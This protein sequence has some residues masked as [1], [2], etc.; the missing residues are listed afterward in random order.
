MGNI[1]IVVKSEPGVIINKEKFEQPI[2]FEGIHN[3]PEDKR[4]GT[5]IDHLFERKPI[6]ILVEVKEK[7]KE[8][9]KG[10]RIM[11]ENLADNLCYYDVYCFLVW[12]E[13]KEGPIYLKD[14]IVSKL[15]RKNN[16]EGLKYAKDKDGNEIINKYSIIKGKWRNI[17][18]EKGKKMTYKEVFNK[19]I[20]E[21]LNGKE[22]KRT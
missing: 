20:D 18:E 16:T 17:I 15:Y 1:E 4:T 7:N 11:M 2:L 19:I 14:C 6:M 22:K 10:Q 9:P 8:L 12:H 21:K 5:D 3:S 13:V